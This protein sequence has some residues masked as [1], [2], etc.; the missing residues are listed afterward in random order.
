MTVEELNAFFANPPENP[1]PSWSEVTNR[2]SQ[3]R[4]LHAMML[5]DSLC[6]APP[7]EDGYRS[8]MVS[9]AQ[10][11]QFWLAIDPEVIAPKLTPALCRELL[12]CGVC[13]QEDEGFY[14]FA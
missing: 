11:D 4:D 13:Y 7:R 14:F 2:R 10:H 12:C 3:H 1:S 6:P 5:L 8:D 9:A